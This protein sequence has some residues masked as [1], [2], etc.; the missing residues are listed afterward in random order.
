MKTNN[1]TQR[2]QKVIANS[3]FCSRRKAELLITSGK[4]KVNN[5]VVT[6]LGTKVSDSDVVSI[7]NQVLHFHDYIYLAFYKPI[8][9]L[10]TLKDPKH[11]PTIMPY[12]SD[13][14]IRIYPVGRLDFDTSGLLLMTNDG[15][16]SNQILHPKYKINKVY[17]VTCQ[18]ILTPMQIKQLE[19]GVKID[20]NIITA[21]A[22]VEVLKQNSK[23]QET[24][25][26]L[27]I[28]QGYKNQVKKMLQA[29]GSKVLNLERIAIGSLS[30][31]GLK[32]GTYRYL[33]EKEKNNL[34]A[35][36]K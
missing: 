15:E 3:G 23:K 24:L 34:L 7:N 26:N 33:S 20:S 19:K 10:T 18:G 9:C 30:L 35:L 17:Q 14:K 11:R 31:K 8:N 28:H 36:A 16:F 2:L 21:H 29:V 4:V 6:T 32:P 1:Q 25:I 12:F 27:T 13:I 22:E 5:Q